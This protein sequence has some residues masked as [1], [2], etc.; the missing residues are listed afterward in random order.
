MP[1]TVDE[2]FLIF[3]HFHESV[4]IPSRRVCGESEFSGVLLVEFPAALEM[5][6]GEMK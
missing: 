4:G 2:G 1:P 6:T 5:M 3:E